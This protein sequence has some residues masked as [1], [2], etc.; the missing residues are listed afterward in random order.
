M[1]AR[2]RSN[3]GRWSDT[4]RNYVGPPENLYLAL[5]RIVTCLKDINKRHNSRVIIQETLYPLSPFLWNKTRVR[6]HEGPELLTMRSI[7]ILELS[8]VMPFVVLQN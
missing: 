5:I 3:K 2:Q 1:V 6:N 4:T 8:P 7:I